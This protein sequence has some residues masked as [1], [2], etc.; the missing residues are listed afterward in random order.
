MLEGLEK[1][2]HPKPLVEFVT[3]LTRSLITKMEGRGSEI[4]IETVLKAETS[5]LERGALD[6]FSEMHH[7]VGLTQP[8]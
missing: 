2:T 7:V 1:A 4:G 5:G 8:P 3:E 6:P